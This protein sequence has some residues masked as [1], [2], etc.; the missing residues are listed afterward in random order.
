MAQTG[1]C[2]LETFFEHTDLPAKTNLPRQS[3][4]Q[5]D[6][7]DSNL[8]EEEMASRIKHKIKQ[9]EEISGIDA[10]HPAEHSYV[11][12]QH[13]IIGQK[14]SA[15]N[16]P[17]QDYIFDDLK[18]ADLMVKFSSNVEFYEQETIQKVIDH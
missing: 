16:D 13:Y 11:D 2:N 17:T 4:S 14:L 10:A 9:Q 7:K 18:L 1:A 3:Y 6:F 5:P 12:F 15:R 8:Y